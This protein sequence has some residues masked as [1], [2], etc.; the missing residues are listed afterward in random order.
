MVP[1]P[2]C[3]TLT[4]NLPIKSKGLPKRS[5]TAITKD[6][7]RVQISQG[8]KFFYQARIIF[9][10]QSGPSGSS[11]RDGSVPGLEHVRAWDIGVFSTHSTRPL[12]AAHSTLGTCP[13]WPGMYDWRTLLDLFGPPAPPPKHSNQRKTRQ[14]PGHPR[15]PGQV[16]HNTATFVLSTPRCLHMNCVAGS[17][18]ISEP[19]FNPTWRP[20][21]FIS[22]GTP[23][24]H[25]LT[26]TWI[27]A[28]WCR[29]PRLSGRHTFI[30]LAKLRPPRFI[31]EAS[32]GIA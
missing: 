13:I 12:P 32:L 31:T 27:C 17:A 15:C 2:R 10:E 29:Q 16:L 5:R 6:P 8:P 14:S 7:S 19:A 22:A 24:G 30:L 1:S 3:F 28:H 26:E 25:Q 20:Q 4:G 21:A 11:P 9:E 23:P 18:I